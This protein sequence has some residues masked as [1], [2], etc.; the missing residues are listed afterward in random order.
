MSSELAIQIQGLGKSYALFAKPQ[1]R[2]K[3]MLWRGRRKYFREFWA[4]KNIDL[5]IHRG[6]TLGIVGANGSGKSTLLG[7][8]CGNLSPT[9]GDILVKGRVAALLELGAG[10]NPEFTG[11]ENVFMNG[12]VLGSTK[13]EMEERFDEIAA[14]ADIGEFIHHPVKTYSS[15]MFVRLAFAVAI[16]VDPDILVIDE[17]LAVGDM[18]FQ[19]KCYARMEAIKRRGATIV[20]VSHAMEGVLDLCDRAV[21][22]HRGQ[23]LFTGK[24][25][26]TV[27]RY[28]K[29][30]AAAGDHIEQVVAEIIKDDRRA[31]RDKELEAHQSAQ[32]DHKKEI[33]LKKNSLSVGG[34]T[35]ENTPADES[36][37]DPHLVSQSAVTYPENGAAIRDPRI[38]AKDGRTVNCLVPGQRYRLCYEVLF[39]ADNSGVFF[40]SMIKTVTGVQLGGG[41][42]PSTKSS[43]FK[44]QAGDLIGVAFE[45]ACMLR[46]GTYFINCGVG[47]KSGRSLNRIIDALAFRIDVIRD[48]FHI[49]NVDF[50]IKAEVSRLNIQ[51]RATASAE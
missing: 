22:L 14:F 46:R 15:G 28:Q 43:G 13:K 20:F 36:L 38:I 4:L 8:V 45:F 26:E 41:Q 39:T 11:R 42:Y 2:L 25:K 23:R 31:D 17:A 44:A 9:C 6:E 10:F 40:R 49:G 1:D 18:A 30:S 51:S 33:H 5:E 37:F 12:I 47:T 16:H 29:L 48:A 19:R 21:L 34:Q 32:Q 35:T 3:Q 24:S 27:A 50:G 7:I